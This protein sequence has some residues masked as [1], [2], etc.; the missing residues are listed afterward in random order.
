M[1]H[2]RTHRPPDVLVAAAC[3]L[4]ALVVTAVALAGVVEIVQ[5]PV[6]PRVVPAVA[7]ACGAL[8]VGLA[9]LRPLAPR[10]TTGTGLVCAAG[11]LAGSVMAIPHTVLIMVVWAASRLTGGVGP[12]DVTPQ[13]ST[14]A[15]HLVT[16]GAALLL[17]MW[18]VG[19]LGDRA[20]PGPRF[21]AWAAALAVAGCLP[22]GLLKITWALGGTIGLTGHSFD[23][24]SF[25]SPGFGDTAL[26]TAVSI[27]V[28]VLMGTRVTSAWLRPA[29][30]GVGT[31][32]SLMLLPVGVLGIV[33]VLPVALGVASTG[34]REIAP[35]V[36]LMVYGC[37]AV[38]GVA[39]A[40]LTAGYWRSTGLSAGSETS[41]T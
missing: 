39:L 31:L 28:S 10:V 15:A 22:Y 41:A 38:W 8:L 32:G 12:F 16:V 34:D 35:W 29:L 4:A 17:V 18:A 7:A 26:L 21:L 25:A 19:P 23:G 9:R 40:C 11:M 27:V 37:F 14:T 20:R 1:T 2:P 3:L 33:D 13:W 6:A 5:M 36:F 24:V 30:T